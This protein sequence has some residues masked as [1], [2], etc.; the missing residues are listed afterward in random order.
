MLQIRVNFT[1]LHVNLK[2]KIESVVNYILDL[3]H[4]GKILGR[5]AQKCKVRVISDDF[6]KS[7]II[8][9]RNASFPKIHV[10]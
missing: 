3:S 10:K 8:V 2:I 9:H 6:K 5:T 4:N 7:R 1:L